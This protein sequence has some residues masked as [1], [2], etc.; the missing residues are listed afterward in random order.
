MDADLFG[1][2]KQPLIHENSVML[3]VLMDIKFEISTF[4]GQLHWVQYDCLAE[5]IGNMPFRND[6]Q[7]SGIDGIFVMTDM[8]QP[9]LKNCTFHRTKRA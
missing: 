4:H 9:V 3:P 2:L 5:K 8:S 1:V 6:E 7:M